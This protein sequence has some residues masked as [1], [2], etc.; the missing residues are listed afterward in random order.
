MNVMAA[1]W[2]QFMT[3]DWFSHMSEGRQRPAAA[4]RFHGLQDDAPERCRA[5]LTRPRGAESLGCRPGRRRRPGLRRRPHAAAHVHATRRDA[6]GSSARIARLRNNQVTAWWDGS[7]IYG[8]DDTSRRRVQARSGSDRAK[9]AHGARPRTAR[10]RGGDPGYLP[11]ARR[12]PI[13]RTPCGRARSPSGFPDNYTAGLS[14]LHNVFAREHNI[15]SSM[16]FAP[17]THRAEDSGLARSRQPGQSHQLRRRDGRRALRGRAAG[18]R[19]RDR[20]DPHHRV[21]DRSCCTTSRSTSGM[22]ANW[23]G[24]VRDDESARLESHRAGPSRTRSVAS[25]TRKSHAMVFD[26]R[27]PAAASSGSAA[28]ITRTAR[29]SRADPRKTDRWTLTDEADLMR[30]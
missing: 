6:S 29:S 23:S 21:D 5:P 25:T 18:R 10:P 28:I 24:L 13:P 22:N 1:F 8:F 11:A 16:R 4:A 20:Q 27:R 12:P 7:Q 9:L 19:R 3:H 2:I 30:G 26:L 15:S 14:F 17:Q